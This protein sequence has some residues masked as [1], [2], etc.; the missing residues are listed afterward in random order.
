MKT[1]SESVKERPM[2]LSI[3]KI[4]I[5][6][7]M[8]AI[9]CIMAPF[10][11][12]LPFTI[13]PISLTNLA[14]YFTVFVLGWKMG[15]ISYLIYLLI[16]LIGVPVFSGFTSGFSKLAGPTGG[17]L[18]GFIFLVIISGWFIE[19]FP[20]KIPM[21]II[22]MLLGNIVTYLFGT[23]WLANLTG[24]TFKQALAIGVLPFLL[25]DLLKIIAAVLI[26]TVLRKQILRSGFFYNR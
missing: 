15:T 12:P 14:I 16:G 2:K 23:I 8:T 10:S 6:G 9:I 7:V 21:Y 4:A 20:N 25:G 24:N 18:I 5:I 3:Y 22:G 26:G 13:V 1:I 19:K 11:I 17:Y